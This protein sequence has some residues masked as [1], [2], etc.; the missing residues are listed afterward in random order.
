MHLVMSVIVTIP[1]MTFIWI[2][3]A[4]LGAYLIFFYIV[5]TLTTRTYYEIVKS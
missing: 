5:Y 1:Q 2:T 3:L 4:S